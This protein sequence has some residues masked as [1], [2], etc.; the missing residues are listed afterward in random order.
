VL[1][2][3]EILL[4]VT[5][6]TSI[7][8]G[9]V[10]LAGNR[11]RD[12]RQW[13]SGRG[14]RDGAR[15]CAGIVVG[16][17][18]RSRRDLRHAGRCSAADR[19]CGRRVAGR[20]RSIAQRTARTRGQQSNGHRAVVAVAGRDRGCSAGI[21]PCFRRHR[22]PISRIHDQPSCRSAGFMISRN[23]DGP[24]RG[25]GRPAT[26]AACGRVRESRPARPRSGAG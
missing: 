14:H 13:S 11:A 21:D 24:A 1:M 9:L 17:P 2:T 20:S 22:Q 15:R 10:R 16:E 6:W 25:S 4:R 3:L 18:G 12:P 7:A 19:C 5:L 26:P 8:C 23:T